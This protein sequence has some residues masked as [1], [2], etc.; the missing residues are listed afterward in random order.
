MVTLMSH[1]IIDRLKLIKTNAGQTGNTET[2]D[3]ALGGKLAAEALAIEV[4]G[5]GVLATP[6]PLEAAAALAQLTVPAPFGHRDKT[7]LDVRVR[8]VG[9]LAAS[10]VKVQWADGVLPALLAEIADNL[11]VE[12]LTAHLHKLL[13]YGPGQFFKT[14]QDT[15]KL[16]G[17][18]AT[19]V[20]VWPCA[21]L[22]GELRVALGEDEQRF[23]SQQV[24][25]REIRWFAF[26]AD[27]RHEL[28]KVEEGYRIALS[29][30]LVI[31]F[32]SGRCGPSPLN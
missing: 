16:P 21:H 22:G 4:E 11:G 28:L 31:N 9:E 19:L 24:Q 6:L 15:E 29:F 2:P 20:L 12:G 17:M 1:A 7:L 26:Y 30:D 14:H 25:C 18:V 8:D 5:F 10:A 13:V 32:Y 3:F 27:C 23:A